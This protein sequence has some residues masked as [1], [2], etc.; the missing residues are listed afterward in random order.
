MARE[1][2]LADRKAPLDAREQAISL[3]EEKLE[4]TLRAMDDNLEALVCQ[5]TKELEDKHGAALDA[6]AADSAA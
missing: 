2:R 5:C 3:R 1:A 4:A 6:L